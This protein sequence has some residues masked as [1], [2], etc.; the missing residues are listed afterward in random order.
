M[1]VCWEFRSWPPS[2]SH[3]QERYR[4]VGNEMNVRPTEQPHQRKVGARSNKEEENES[5]LY[6]SAAMIQE[7][8]EIG[9]P[10]NCTVVFSPTSSHSSSE[11]RAGPDK[12]TKKLTPVRREARRTM[13]R[14]KFQ[15]EYT[16][17]SQQ[18]DRYQIATET[19]SLH[20]DSESSNR[21]RPNTATMT[22][23]PP[24]LSWLDRYENAAS[25]YVTR[26]DSFASHASGSG[27]EAVTSLP[28]SALPRRNRLLQ[29]DVSIRSLGRE[30][31]RV[32]QSSSAALMSPN[33]T[34]RKSL[35]VIQRQESLRFPSLSSGRRHSDLDDSFQR[36]SSSELG[37]SNQSRNE[38]RSR[39]QDNF[40]E[41]SAFETE[42]RGSERRVPDDLVNNRQNVAALPRQTTHDSHRSDFGQ[43]TPSR[44][45]PS[46]NDTSQ[47]DRLSNS[48]VGF[49]QQNRQDSGQGFRQQNQS[50]PGYEEIEIS[51]GVF[52]KLHGK[53][54][55]LTA[56]KNGRVGFQECVCCNFS[57][58]CLVDVEFVLCS[59]CD[60]VSRFTRQDGISVDGC[61][62]VG[63]GLHASDEILAFDT[64]QRGSERRVPDESANNRR[65]QQ[66]NAAVPRH[67]TND[68]H[69]SDFGQT[70]TSRHQASNNSFNQNDRL[71]NRM[72]RFEQQYPQGSGERNRFLDDFSDSYPSNFSDP[73]PRCFRQQSER[74]G[75]P[76]RHG[77]L[78]IEIS[79]GVYEQLRGA[80]ETWIAIKEGRI[81]FQECLCC[82]L[83]MVCRDDVEFSLC[84]NCKVVSPVT[85]Q[86]GIIVDGW[87]GVGLGLRAS[88]Y[89]QENC[90]SRPLPSSQNRTGSHKFSS[91]SYRTS[92]SEML[93]ALDRGLQSQY[94]SNTTQSHRSYDR[95]Q[96][97]DRNQVSFDDRGGREYN[98]RY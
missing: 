92:G 74:G 24:T 90:R 97:Y 28:N 5:P 10:I 71:V 34:G 47:N 15:Q 45:Q 57:M 32:K 29:R 40:Y 12:Q 73:D 9:P 20:S 56:I 61:R 93:A 96:V 72:R 30:S 44:Q 17:H 25:A 3:L 42:R 62:G 63:L 67:P 19:S 80:E 35:C 4:L 41:V 64:E 83:N 53:E 55:T 49:E 14:E 88:E 84:P 38:F 76:Q 13:L 66:R 82:N 69:R 26:R 22:T 16:Q 51:P 86:D 54:E 27:D 52:E 59:N 7:I 58:V 95:T 77:C 75:A 78:E 21:H 70:I 31:F 1:K 60:V 91:Q 50:G 85:R 8:A 37:N 43:P 94:R 2:S 36:R 39:V 81:G 87:G 79:P 23:T 46:N 98:T 48:N 18:R 11:K 68:P 6:A 33:S 65:L 89:Y